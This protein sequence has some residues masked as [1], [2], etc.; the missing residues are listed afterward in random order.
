LTGWRLAND[1][2]TPNTVLQ[3]N[4]DAVTSYAASRNNDVAIQTSAMFTKNITGAWAVGNGNGGLGNGVTRA[5]STYYHCFAIINGG[6]A[7]AYF[8][9]SASAA[10]RPAGTTAWRRVGTIQ[11]DGSS[12]I[13]GFFQTGDYFYSVETVIYSNQNG[14][15][16]MALLTISMIPLGI[17][18]RPLLTVGTSSFNGGNNSLSLAPADKITIGLTA[19]SG[20][21]GNTTT[22]VNSLSAVEGPLSNTVQQIGVSYSAPVASN[23]VY[24]YTHGWID[25]RGQ[26]GGL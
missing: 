17:S 24:L 13:V 16:A 19:A 20:Y 18:V 23:G 3:F 15:R 11:T 1:T 2:T 12:N 22:S 4:T 21:N 7:D 26:D 14:T 10:N 6:V 9:T 5:A 8:D 25:R